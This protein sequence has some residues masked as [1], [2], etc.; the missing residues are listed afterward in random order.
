[1]FKWKLKRC[2]CA[3]LPAI[4]MLP[5]PSCPQPDG[6]LAKKIPTPTFYCHTTT[7]F[8]CHTT[9]YILLP[10]TFDCHTYILLVVVFDSTLRVARA[11]VLPWRKATGRTNWSPQNNIEVGFCHTTTQS[12]PTLLGTALELALVD[13]WIDRRTDGRIDG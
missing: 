11:L 10:P 1:M 5:G 4:L 9:T 8:Y 6:F 7:L 3:R 2:P 12:I 13:R